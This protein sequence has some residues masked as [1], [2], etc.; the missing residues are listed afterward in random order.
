[1][2]C[3]INRSD[4]WGVVLRT[5]VA[6]AW[7]LLAG[8]C[9]VSTDLEPTSHEARVPSAAP[10][11][12]TQPR[13]SAARDEE[14]QGVAAGPDPGNATPSEDA[15][16]TGSQEPPV[17]QVGQ[18]R[19]ASDNA[20]P[21][22]PLPPPVCGA[23][24]HR[25][26]ARGRCACDASH[27]AG[28]VDGG[29]LPNRVLT[30]LWAVNDGEKVERDD[31]SHPARERNSAWDGQRVRLFG[32]RNEVLAFQV[33]AQAGERD[34]TSLRAQL[35]ELTHRDPSKHRAG[36]TKIRY[37][38]PAADPTD[39]VDRPI[40]IFS[41]HYLD[42][43]VPTTANWITA[44][45]LAASPTDMLGNKPV[46]LVPEHARAGRGGFPLSVAAGQNQG[47][48]FEIYVEPDLAAGLY[49]GTIQV[50]ADGEPWALP[51]E[52]EVFDFTLPDENSWNAMLYFEAEQT[53]RYHGAPLAAAYHRLAHRQRVEFV[54]GYDVASAT[55]ELGR[56]T[57]SDF[58]PDCGYAGPGVG[59]G[60]RIIPRTMYGPG[61]LFSE[62]GSAWRESDVWVEFV[63]R[64][65]ADPIT[66]LY[67]PDEPGSGQ[68]PQ[69]LSIAANV[70]GNPGVGR[71]LPILV[72]HGF[73]AALDPAIDIWATVSS[74]F[75][76]SRAAL[77]RAHGDQM[78]FYNGQRPH[79]GSVLIDSPATDPR[80]QAWASFKHDVD[81]YFYWHVNHWYHNSQAQVGY[82]R[83][84]NVWA[85]PKTFYS[86]RGAFA[87]GDGVLVYPGQDVLHPEQDRGIPGPVHTIQLANLRRG[88]QDHLYLTLLERRGETE[89]VEW[90]LQQIVPRVLDEVGSG[91]GVQFPE[92]GDA[93]DAVRYE[94]GRALADDSPVRAVR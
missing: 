91:E 30:A 41:Q 78:W 55:A 43:A 68:F 82:D 8:G 65:V 2:Q 3:F 37:R 19:R 16:A 38:A 9:S 50:E 49:E 86:R 47:L 80:V 52:L 63:R 59:R 45:G 10:R 58:T 25:L 29:C 69:I 46:A 17:E 62:P 79:V 57:G 15:P 18:P 40:Q 73:T 35:P 70:H 56:F 12:A 64:H 28:G 36:S 83:V 72:T 5:G 42:V 89:L 81:V 84:Q 34:V 14:T 13:E 92:A 7:L 23:R 48:W 60:N 76:T 21:R 26:D 94:L 67:M 77:E 75:S 24:G 27:H 4:T 66:F 54:S 53:A 90:A 93:F 85:D 11:V 20:R 39:Y 51:V 6:L 74:H 1:M 31:R 44:P 32:A 88:A 22:R 71:D 33:I 87:N 61:N